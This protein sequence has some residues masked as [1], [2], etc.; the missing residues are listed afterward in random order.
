MKKL[1]N[2][3]VA[4]TYGKMLKKP[5]SI[6]DVMGEVKNDYRMAKEQQWVDTLRKKYTYSVNNDVL[7]Q[8]EN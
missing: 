3:P 7:K 5:E 4:V 6:D 2:Y 1:T 8:L